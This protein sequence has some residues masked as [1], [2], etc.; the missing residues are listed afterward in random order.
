MAF[1]GGRKKEEKPKEQVAAPKTELEKFEILFKLS[2]Q[3]D[4][5]LGTINSLIRPTQKTTIIV[6]SIATGMP[7]FDYDV[8]Q[9]GGIPR[10]R[11]IEIFG[12]ESAGKTSFTLHVVAEEQRTGGIAAF[13]DAE[14]ALD[15]NWAAKLGVNIDKLVLNQPDS[16]EQALTVVQKLIESQSVSII[17]I[18]SAAAL[19][20]EAE[21]AGE[22]TDQHVGL[23]ARMMAKALRKL[24]GIAEKNKVTI[25]FINQIR[26]K[27]GVMFGNPETT[28]TGRALKHYASM[29]IDVRRRDAITLSG[30]KE[31]SNVI[32][33]QIRLKAVKNKV[34]IP[35][36]ECLVSL[37]YEDG[38]D[39]AADLVSYAVDKGIIEQTG[40][41]FKYG[42]EKYHGLGQLSDA[43]KSDPKKEAEI[44]KAL[45]KAEAIAGV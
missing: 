22:M 34:G 13:V 29:R 27:I 6:P 16:G 32:G 15:L 24:S 8:S 18:D 28:P 31:D 25:I 23:Q 30:S 20:P 11:I 17:I 2:G 44:R 26:E 9:T 37:M 33:H 3:L 5:E 21:L 36:R 10:G 35:F 4:K 42:E 41:W 43:I 38:F 12:P 40:A 14:H 19:T 1:G 7:S 39:K 45:K